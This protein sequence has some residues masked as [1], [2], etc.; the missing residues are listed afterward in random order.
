[1]RDFHKHP[2][3]CCIYFLFLKGKLI[4]IGQTVDL[5]NRMCSHAFDYLYDSLRYICCQPDK[6]EEYEKRLIKILKPLAN[7]TY[8]TANPNRIKI[9]YRVPKWAHH[10]NRILSFSDAIK[11]GNHPWRTSTLGWL[12]KEAKTK[13]RYYYKAHGYKGTFMDTTIANLL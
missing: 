7:R 3:I 13:F 12:L 4:Y 1:M 5:R 11:T 6:L 9:P 2:K 10:Y 8:N